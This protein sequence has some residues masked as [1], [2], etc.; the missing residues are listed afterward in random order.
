MAE[1]GPTAARRRLGAQLRGLREAAGISGEQAAVILDGSQ[2]KISR[3]ESGVTR[4]GI[5]DVAALLK[6]YEADDEL[7]DSLLALAKV[8]AS[9]SRSW[10]RDY[11]DAFGVQVR[12]RAALESEAFAI[13]HCCPFVIPGVLQ[14]PDYTQVVFERTGH[15]ISRENIELAI[16]Y[17]TAR[18]KH[19]LANVSAYRVLTTPAALRWRPSA[20]FD[21][22]PQLRSLISDVT[23]GNCFELRILSEYP[24][25]GILAPPDFSIFTFDDEAV[26][27]A[28]Y[29]ELP[30]GFHAL[31][32][33]SEIQY[34]DE[35]FS[36]LWD[37]AL[38]EENS[39]AYVHDMVKKLDS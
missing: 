27:A 38:T 3:L 8:A 31:E 35:V 12:Q 10:W 21:P 33:S 28:G 18:K 13:L 7:Y 16:S 23:A 19:V 6:F 24:A 15:G 22:R 20:T 17:Q 4:P 32:R 9:R 26:P 5:A 1:T 14:T 36:V 37:M 30:T 25:D 29:L 2:A 39:L 11:V 34:Y